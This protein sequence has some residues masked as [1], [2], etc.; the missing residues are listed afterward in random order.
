MKEQLLGVQRERHAGEGEFLRVPDA[1]MTKESRTIFNNFAGLMDGTYQEETKFKKKE[2]HLQ[3]KCEWTEERVG[4]YL[5]AKIPSLLEFLENKIH[6][7]EVMGVSMFESSGKGPK[8][9]AHVFPNKVSLE[10]SL[11]N[12]MRIKD[13]YHDNIVFQSEQG[14][15]LAYVPKNTSA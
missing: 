12:Q 15:Q 5:G 2:T 7:R 10:E 8:H 14:D 6:L 4:D 13:Q 1:F 11:V 9:K 3:R